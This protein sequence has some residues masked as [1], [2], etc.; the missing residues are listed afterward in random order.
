MPDMPGKP[1]EQHEGDLEAGLQF[2]P[3]IIR[4]PRATAAGAGEQPELPLCARASL[5]EVFQQLTHL[6]GWVVPLSFRD[7][8]LR[9]ASPLAERQ[10]H[11]PGPL[12]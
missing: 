5:F 1:I 2:I 8:H 11:L 6:T 12:S 7:G 3:L 10:T 9:L 4:N